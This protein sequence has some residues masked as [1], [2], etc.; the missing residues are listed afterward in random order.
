MKVL[1]RNLLAAAAL[2]G[3][4]VFSIVGSAA[5]PAPAADDP[6]VLSADKDFE[7]ATAK[8]DTAA[9]GKLLDADFVWIDAKG[10]I[11]TR[12]QVLASVPKAGMS[13]TKDAE[14]QRHDYGQIETM[15]ANRGK[16]HVMRI[17]V[18]RPAGWRA[19]VYQEVESLGAPPKSAK[20]LAR[21]WATHP[22]MKPSE[23]SLPPTRD[24]KPRL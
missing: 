9:L 16:M 23:P 8:S 17:W 1:R 10:R 3:A 22:R 15:Q 21:A 13:D 11:E 12:A 14:T 18:K 2:S 7:Q 20:I 4:L 6:A 24:W 5:T 19:L